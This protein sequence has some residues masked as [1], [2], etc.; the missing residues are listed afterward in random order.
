MVLRGIPP[1]VPVDKIQADLTVQE[2]W[3]VKISHIMKTDKATQTLITKYPVLSLFKPAL[4][5][6]KYYRSKKYVTTSYSERSTRTTSLYVNSLTAN[7]LTI[8][9]TSVVS[10][11]SV[12]YAISHMQHENANNPLARFQNVSTAAEPTQPILLTVLHMNN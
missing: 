4:T 6:V 10:P 7:L 5:Y 9:L 11:P 2:L 1:H 3:V 12:S 8:H